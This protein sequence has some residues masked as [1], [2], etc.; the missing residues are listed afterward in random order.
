MSLI[1]RVAAGCQVRRGEWLYHA[2]H[3]EDD[4][5]LR[6]WSPWWNGAP[7]FLSNSSEVAHNFGKL[8]R[9]HRL[10]ELRAVRDLPL[11]AVHSGDFMAWSWRHLQGGTAQSEVEA[12]RHNK[13]QGIRVYGAFAEDGSGYEE[14]W[15]VGDEIAL[16]NTDGLVVTHVG[17]R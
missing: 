9:E 10:V 6:Q 3:N 15:G 17:G 1:R 12:L 7:M 4:F 2:T 16:W 11:I 8:Y 14:G 13:Y 5:V